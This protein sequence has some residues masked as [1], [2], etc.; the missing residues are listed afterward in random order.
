MARRALDLGFY[1]SLAGIVTFPTAEELREVARIVP[2][3]RL[4]IE[5]DART[6]RRFRTAASATSRRYVVRVARGR[7][8]RC[9]AIGDGRRWPRQLT[10]N[11][12]ALFGPT[13]LSIN[14]LAR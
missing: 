11:F 1:I 4:L 5:T 3:D 2:A 8:R 10:Q 14:G 13:V 9:A 6:W 7:R 12:D